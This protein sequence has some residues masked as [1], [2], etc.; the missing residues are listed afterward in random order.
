MRSTAARGCDGRR[1]V[2]APAPAPA[3]LTAYQALQA[4]RLQAGQRVL[5][6]AAAGGVG[7]A[8]VQ[9]AKAQGLQARPR[10][11][12]LPAS[13]A[14]AVDAPPSHSSCSG[15]LAAGR[16]AAT[17]CSARRPAP[18]NA[19]APH[20][21]PPACDLQVVATA[22]AANVEFVRRLGADQVIDYRQ[23]RCAPARGAS[24]APAA[25]AAAGLGAG[26][27]W[28][29]TASHHEPTG[30]ASAAAGCQAAVRIPS[31][32]SRHMACIPHA[33]HAWHASNVHTNAGLRRCW[34]A[35]RCTR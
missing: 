6:H 10:R 12:S 32:W 23:Q 35:S 17:P 2:P 24:A 34:P 26:L 27:D 1:P 20:L 14:S 3:A 16:S 7:S 11:A 5:V 25:R 31:R 28:L 21:S 9:I 22:S 4:A 30:L 19:A 15:C 8:A 29:G 18:H 33:N 13:A